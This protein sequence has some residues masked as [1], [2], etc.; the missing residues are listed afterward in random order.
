MLALRADERADGRRSTRGELRV[1]LEGP[2]D[3]GPMED[4]A[5]GVD[6]SE[7]IAWPNPVMCQWL[8]VEWNGSTD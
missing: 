1:K 3:V 5:I 2:E 6:R 4:V 7:S 8:Y